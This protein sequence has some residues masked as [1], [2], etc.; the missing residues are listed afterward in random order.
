MALLLQRAFDLP[1]ADVDEP[2]FDDVADDHY[3][4]AAV[5]SVKAAGITVGCS[6]EPP[7]YCGADRVTRAHMAAFLS[8]AITHTETQ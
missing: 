7:K 4:F 8:R 2:S 1:E 3:A 5:E 6:T